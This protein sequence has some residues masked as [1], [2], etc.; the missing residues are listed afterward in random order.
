MSM[1]DPRLNARG[2]DGPTPTYGMR[3][4][5]VKIAVLRHT[6]GSQAKRSCL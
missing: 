6:A 1:E 3:K 2:H 4:V 5:E